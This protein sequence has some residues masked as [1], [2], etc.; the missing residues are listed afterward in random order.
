MSIVSKPILTH[1][2]ILWEQFL[3]IFNFSHAH[4]FSTVISELIL[5]V[6]YLVKKHKKSWKI[7]QIQVIPQ[8]LENYYANFNKTWHVFYFKHGF[9]DGVPG[10]EVPWGATAYPGTRD[11]APGGDEAMPQ[12]PGQVRP[13]LRG[14]PVRTRQGGPEVHLSGIPANV[15]SFP[16]IF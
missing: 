4:W 12:H 7:E 11:P 13:E 1:Y 16:G 3:C 14:C 9:W 10:E 6:F 2:E 15:G 5:T 8:Y